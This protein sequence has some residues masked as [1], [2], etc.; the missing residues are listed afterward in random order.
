M[1]G[2][3][4]DN[5]NE[6]NARLFIGDN[7]GD[8]TATMRCQ[9]ALGHDGLH[10]EQFDREGGPV[11]ITWTADERRRCD[12]GCGQWRHAHDSEIVKCPN[13][14]DDHEYSDC[15]F[16]HPDKPAMTCET[17]GKTYYYEQ[18]HKRDCGTFACTACGESGVGKHK[19]PKEM[20]AFLK[21]GE[22]NNFAGEPV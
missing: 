5:D 14:A 20:E 6:C 15:A 7:Y 4:A 3:P 17:C 18:G 13:D 22:D 12:H 10:Q 9:L 16:C 8:G 1:F 21:R 19:C 2:E 11:T